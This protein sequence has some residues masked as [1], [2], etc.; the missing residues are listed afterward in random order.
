LK[1]NAEIVDFA[2][3]FSYF[4]I[5][6]VT[7][8][9]PSKTVF[10]AFYVDLPDSLTFSAI[11]LKIKYSGIS[12]NE[13]NITLYKCSDF[14]TS[15]KTCNTNWEVV[16]SIKDSV[17]QLVIAEVDSFSAY[18][19]GDPG[20]TTTTTTTT[21]PATTTTTTTTTI[22]TTTTTT[23]SSGSSSGCSL[24][25]TNN[26][27]CSADYVQQKYINSDCSESWLNEEHCDYGCSSGECNNPPETNTTA[28]SDPDD[29]V[30]TSE[31]P[32]NN[33]TDNLPDDASLSDIQGPNML[34]GFV[35]MLSNNI[36]AVAIAASAASA[37][38]V[39]FFKT[40]NKASIGDG[41]SRPIGKSYRAGSN[42]YRVVR[43]NKR[44]GRYSRYSKMGKDQ[45]IVLNL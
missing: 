30:L 28:N 45:N 21:I 33:V 5:D 32:Q 8:T 22:P 7:T 39:G 13:N 15:S 29:T 25:A 23:A 6:S 35:T 12:I 11:T 26:Y 16:P 24:H 38:V 37:F 41:Y 19:L 36:T 10:K 42:R 43:Y 4:I 2:Y 31:T 27:R 17:N 14:D 3:N 1:K 44:M 9:I 34:T 20:N 18:A 40:R